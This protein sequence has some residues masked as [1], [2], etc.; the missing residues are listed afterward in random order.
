MCEI[1]GSITKPGFRR[2]LLDIFPLPVPKKGAAS[3][4]I[5]FEY[6]KS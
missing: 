5:A 2:V 1:V 4:R 6:L 3:I